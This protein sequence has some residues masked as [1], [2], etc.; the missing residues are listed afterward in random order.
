MLFTHFIFAKAEGDHTLGSLGLPYGVALRRWIT[1]PWLLITY[2]TQPQ[3]TLPASVPWKQSLLI[4]IALILSWFHPT[5]I[6]LHT[7]IYICVST[8][9][10]KLL[11]TCLLCICMCIHYPLHCE[12]HFSNTS[13]FILLRLKYV[14]IFPQFLLF[15]HLKQSAYINWLDFCSF[16]IQTSTFQLILLFFS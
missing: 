15:L 12:S 2:F 16:V 13:L 3:S 4:H 7:Y 1:H 9:P 10:I 11:S 6:S 8:Y 14:D 5:F